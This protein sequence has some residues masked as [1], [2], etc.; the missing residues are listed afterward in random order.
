ML[1]RPEED[2]AAA[3]D[4]EPPLAL[5]SIETFDRVAGDRGVEQAAEGAQRSDCPVPAELLRPFT[6]ATL[7]L[8]ADSSLNAAQPNRTGEWVLWGATGLLGLL[9]IFVFLREPLRFWEFV[10]FSAGVAA[11]V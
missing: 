8:P 3:F 10:W 11:F 7:R 5:M 9:L 2:P 4:D 1:W 6:Q